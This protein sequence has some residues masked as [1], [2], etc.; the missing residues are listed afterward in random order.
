[1][2]IGY[3]EVRFAVKSYPQRNGCC[4][5][6]LRNRGM[7]MNTLAE[8][9]RGAIHKRKQLEFHYHSF[10]RVVEPMCLGEVKH[11]VWQ[12]RAHQIGG[13]SSSSRRLPDCIPR[14][15]EVAEMVDVA[16]LPHGFEVPNFCTPGDKAFIRIV[17]QL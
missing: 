16:I 9:I 5:K 4:L 7:R 11:G 1:M 14:L 15:F 13:R 8:V 12:L 17:A 10:L 3:R 6:F 2:E